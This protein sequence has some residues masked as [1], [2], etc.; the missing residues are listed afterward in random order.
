[1]DTTFKLDGCTKLRVVNTPIYYGDAGSGGALPEGYVALL[2]ERQPLV[3]PGA[4]SPNDA[5]VEV[6]VIKAFTPSE[7]RALA[8]VILSAATEARG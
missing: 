3:L 8:S 6:R 2:E 1:M 5:P 4:E 7:A